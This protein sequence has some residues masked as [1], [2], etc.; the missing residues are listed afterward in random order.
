LTYCTLLIFIW[1]KEIKGQKG[2]RKK[3]YTVREKGCSLLS[4][5]PSL[6]FYRNGGAL[7]YRAILHYVREGGRLVH[8]LATTLRK[9]CPISQIA[10][11]DLP[12]QIPY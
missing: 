3:I 11:T 4:D 7:G 12:H 6:F 2:E 1:G 10:P 8:C 5:P 9:Q